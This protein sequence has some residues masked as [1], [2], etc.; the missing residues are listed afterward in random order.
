MAKVVH[1]SNAEHRVQR[2]KAGLGERTEKQAG[3]EPRGTGSKAG[4][5]A[6]QKQARHAKQREELGERKLP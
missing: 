1:G 6:M 2:E 3:Q 4:S 5:G